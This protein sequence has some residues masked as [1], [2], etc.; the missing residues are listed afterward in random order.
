M[1]CRSF[2]SSSFGESSRDIYIFRVLFDWHTA[3]RSLDTPITLSCYS[4]LSRI[5]ILLN[6][7]SHF[8][9]HALVCVCVFKMTFLKIEQCRLCSNKDLHRQQQQQ[10]QSTKRVDY[11]PSRGHH[12]PRRVL[13]PARSLEGQ[14]RYHHEVLSRGGIKTRSRGHGGVSRLVLE[15]GRGTP[16]VQLGVEQRSAQGHGRIARRGMDTIRAGMRGHRMARGTN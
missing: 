15:R 9:L 3:A 8:T 4:R 1:R 7:F 10:Q 11:R 5:I 12:P 6:N 2:L 13:R 14:G 16:R